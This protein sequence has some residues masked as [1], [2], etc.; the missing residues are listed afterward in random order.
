MQKKSDFCAKLTQILC[1]IA[2][3]VPRLLPA[4]A[5]SHHPATRLRMFYLIAISIYLLCY[6]YIRVW[7]SRL[8]T[9][10]AR[11]RLIRAM[12]LVT[13]LLPLVHVGEPFLATQP[14]VV[15]QSIAYSWAAVIMCLFPLAVGAEPLHLVL[16]KLFPGQRLLS[17]PQALSATAL[18]CTLM[19]I[20][21]SWNARHPRL[22]T[23]NVSL[24][25]ARQTTPPLVV[26]A[27]SDLHAGKLV[28]RDWVA[29]IVAKINAQQPDL[30]LLLGDILDDHTIQ[31][32]G[33]LA[34]LAELRAPLGV[35]A[36]LG[37]HEW[38]LRHDW[39]TRR[40]AELGFTVLD[41][42]SLVIDDRL[43]LVGRRDRSAERFGLKRQPLAQLLAH[44]PPLPILVMDHNPRQLGEAEQVGAALQLSGHTHHGQLFPF[45][46]IT[47]QLFDL[48]WGEMQRGAT[49]YYVS[50]G[51]GVW[52]PPLRTSSVPEIIRIELEFNDAP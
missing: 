13:L 36:I 45:N 3:A 21:G 14:I 19:V 18:L 15:L 1:T 12:D 2:T 41:D 39:S 40:L 35:V 30:I 48:S 7:V 5:P 29:D 33:S 34:A 26:V 31:H 51:V 42:E 32:N 20:G 23:L 6:V 47:R 28:N 49:R 16:K 27:I 52:G 43:L 11:R 46:F 37:N 50:C 38:Y 10:M 4:A 17:G 25:S 24:A 9:G 22:R 8:L 44:Q